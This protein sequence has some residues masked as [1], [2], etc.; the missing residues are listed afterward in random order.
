MHAIQ[1]PVSTAGSTSTNSTESTVLKEARPSPGMPTTISP[2]KTL[3][4]PIFH[5]YQTLHVLHFSK[6]PGYLSWPSKM[7]NF[8][9]LPLFIAVSSALKLGF[10][11]VL[12]LFGMHGTAATLLSSSITQI[13]SRTLKIHCPSGFL[14]NSENHDACMLVATH[15][16]ASL[17]YLFVGDRGI[18]DSLL[19]KTMVVIPPQIL[20]ALWLRTGDMVQLLAM[21]FVA[22]QKGWDGVGLLALLI[23]SILM[24]FRFRHGFLA[25]IFCEKNGV[26]VSHKSFEFSGRTPMVGAIQKLSGAR[27]WQWMDDILAPCPRRDVW[28]RILSAENTD[29]NFFEEEVRT[30]TEPDK[31]W[32]WMCCMVVIIIFLL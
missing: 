21:T 1:S 22:S 14:S 11:I 31:K 13:V 23:I 3:G 2:A 28:A 12:S 4:H 27:S 6:S 17:W 32:V 18:V 20:A 19:N 7:D 25:R 30:L 9:A 15:P 10:V 5:R 29:V 8:L 16:N 26:V 24:H